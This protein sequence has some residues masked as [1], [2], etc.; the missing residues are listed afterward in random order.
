MAG[1]EQVVIYMADALNRAR[2]ALRT[3]LTHAGLPS[4]RGADPRL[5]E[6]RRLAFVFVP[7]L[8]LIFVNGLL[9]LRSFDNVAARERVVSHTHAVEAQ[10]AA[11]ETALGDAETGQRGYLLTG[12]ATYL[13]PYTAA[14][15]SIN[16]QVAR[17]Q[18]LTAGDAT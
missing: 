6:A 9:A 7:L 18:A 10:I 14:R 3:R 2:N 15:A 1:K 11:V 16:A 12:D 8:C 4:R 5:H 17:L 13:A